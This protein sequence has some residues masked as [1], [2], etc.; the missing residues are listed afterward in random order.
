MDIAALIYILIAGTCW[1]SSCLFVNVF[2][3][4]GFSPL[5]AAAVRNIVAALLFLIAILI[6]D[7]KKLKVQLKEL[8]LILFAGVCLYGT[9]AS[10]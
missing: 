3:T 5:Q 6:T 1:G 10:Y 4:V 2:V 8:I 9:G 7:R